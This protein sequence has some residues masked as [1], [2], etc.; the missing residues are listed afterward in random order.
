VLQ[1]EEIEYLTDFSSGIDTVRG[2]YDNLQVVVMMWPDPIRIEVFRRLSTAVFLPLQ[3]FTGQI[4]HLENQIQDLK[5][6]IHD[7]KDEIRK[8]DERHL[9]QQREIRDF[10]DEIRKSNER[11]LDQQREI[12]DFKDEIRKSDERHLDQ[13]REIRSLQDQ[14]NQLIKRVDALFQLVT[15]G[16]NKQEL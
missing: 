11:H 12:R 3:A 14:N 8:S 16:S 1:F 7:F 13:Q 9:D 6:Q 4:Q 10:K 2:I 5:K 15:Q